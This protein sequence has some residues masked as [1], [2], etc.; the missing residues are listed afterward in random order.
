MTVRPTR[1][2]QMD[3]TAG[4][5]WLTPKGAEHRVFTAQ[6]EQLRAT[7]TFNAR[8]F[9]R[10]IV[11]NTRSNFNQAL[12]SFNIDQHQ[13]TLASQLLFAYKLNWQTVMYLGYSD[14]RDVLSQNNDFAMQDRQFFFKLSYA[15]QR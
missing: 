15:F 10:T 12:Y 2:L 3:L 4:N 1:H 9:L 7:Y 5:S 8:M 11:Q 13:G 6:I 14:L